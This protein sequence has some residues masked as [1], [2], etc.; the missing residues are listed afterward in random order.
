MTRA[1]FLLPFLVTA[2][3]TD[4]KD[5]TAGD[6]AVTSD[7][8][9]VTVKETIPA[10]GSVT[11]DYRAAIEFELSDA[12]ETATVVSDIAGTTTLSSDNETVI[13]TPNDPLSPSTAYSVTLNYCGGSAEISFTTS[14]YGTPISDTSSLVGNTYELDLAAARIVQPDGIGSVLSSYLTQSILIGVSDV[15]STEIQMLGAIGKEK[16]SPA[17]QDYCDPTIDFPAAD[18]SA[19][20]FFTIGPQT[21]TLSVAGYNIEIGDLEITGTFKSDGSAF[22]GGTLAGTID[23]RPLDPLVGDEEGAICELAG[24]FGAACEACSSDGEPFCLSL[25]ADQI[26]AEEVSGL[27]LVEVVG[28][29]CEGCE[30]GPPAPD[31]VCA[32][33]TG[34]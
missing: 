18:F 14:D 23:T 33:D 24:S 21:T 19:Q 16:V 8:C 22:A 12:D 2:C 13:F 26:T 15:T 5:D 17:E 9:E 3:A 29:D 4:G 10:N 28:N 25:V 6:T 27:T 7:S 32:T 34:M 31:A 1:I 11:A 20:P 30:S